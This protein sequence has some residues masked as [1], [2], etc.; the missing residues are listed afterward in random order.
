MV[1]NSYLNALQGWVSGPVQQQTAIAYARTPEGPRRIKIVVR[2]PDNSRIGLEATLEID[3]EGNL[4]VSN[5]T[6]V[7]AT[8]NS[9]DLPLQASDMRGQSYSV[10]A[11]SVFNDFRRMFSNWSVDNSSRCSSQQRIVCPP[12]PGAPCISH[13]YCAPRP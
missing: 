4:L 9:I 12:E 5:V 1:R 8:A 2:T 11:S 3:I 7:R 13:I 10:F 6:T